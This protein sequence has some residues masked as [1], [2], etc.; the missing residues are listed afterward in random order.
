MCES[1]G[2]MC[3]FEIYKRYQHFWVS[4]WGK[5]YSTK[6]R[7]HLV[8]KHNQYYKLQIWDTTRNALRMETIHRAVMELFGPPNPDPAYYT[9]LDHIDQDKRNNRIDNLRWLP[10][11]KNQLNRKCAGYTFNKVHKKYWAQLYI[12]TNVY[13][14]HFETKMGA[15]A[16]YKRAKALAMGLTKEQYEGPIEKLKVLLKSA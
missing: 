8:Q 7:R 2:R 1:E 13:L 9:D 6:V 11:W 4:N 5:V 15:I 12:R 14:G 16:K 3:E 10:K